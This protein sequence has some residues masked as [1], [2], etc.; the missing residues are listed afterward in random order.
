MEAALS[1]RPQVR[2]TDTEHEYVVA[3]EG[4]MREPHP[5]TWFVPLIDEAHGKAV[6]EQL[7]EVVL[8]IRKLSYANAAAWKCL[9]YWVKKMQQDRRAA[10]RLRVLCEEAHS[11][12]H[13]GMP[14]LRVFGRERL[15]IDVYANGKLSPAQPS[16]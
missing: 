15:V 8:D 9:V 7:R 14:A 12:Q 3:F 16:P 6:A 5:D 11:W 13:V 4:L 1:T 2:I 10:Y